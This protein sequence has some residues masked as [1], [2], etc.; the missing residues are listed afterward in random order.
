MTPG[1]IADKTELTEL[2]N[3]LFMYCDAKQWDQMLKEVFT[4][5][6]WFDASSA[7]AGEPRNMDAKDVCKMWDDGFSGLDAIHHQAGHYLITVQSDTADVFGYA[8]A[9]HYKKETTKGN[10]RTFTG[11]Y[12]LKAERSPHGWRLSQF[13][14]NLKYMEGNISME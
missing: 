1:L 3:K 13:K 4:T 7:G 9:T 6:I 11:S 5:A 12:D 8:V 2:A 10:T 14:Y